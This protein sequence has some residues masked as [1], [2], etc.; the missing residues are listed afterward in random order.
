MDKVTSYALSCSA[1]TSALTVRRRGFP[2]K[3]Y[4]LGDLV[5]KFSEFPHSPQVGAKHFQQR[6]E[7]LP[8]RN[9]G[10]GT[11]AVTILP[12]PFARRTAATARAA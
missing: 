5:C 9:R 11:L 7:F 8:L 6:A 12:I 3:R 2:I 4:A 1:P 10:F